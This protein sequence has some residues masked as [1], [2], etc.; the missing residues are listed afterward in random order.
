[1]GHVL[2][3]RPNIRL[4]DHETYALEVLR[5]VVLNPVRAQMVRRPEDYAW[6][7]HRAVLGLAP[8]P[9]WLAVD[10]VLVQF[11]SERDIARAAY[12]E[13][14]D[15]A[16]GSTES[17][18]ANLVGQIYLGSEEWMQRVHERVNLKPR[19]ADHPRAQRFLPSA[20]MAEVIRCVAEVFSI[21]E[22]EI[23][24]GRGGLARTVAAWIAWNEGQLTAGE[25]AKGLQFRCTGYVARLVSRC[26]RE[27][28]R[29]AR[30]QQT[31]DRC[32]STLRGKVTSTALTPI[33]RRR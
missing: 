18:W 15:A 32:I 1:M 25:I 9:R 20:S 30:V 11:G 2:Q 10:D 21:D 24:F 3:G 16:I 17:P 8:G 29:D 19:S 27:L 31:T 14:I 4:I 5:Y 13:F 23:R 22:N 28:A 33:I 26:E 6:S 12:R 7:S